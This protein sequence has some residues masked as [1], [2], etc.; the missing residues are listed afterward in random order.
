M[1]RVGMVYSRLRNDERM[2]LDA[3]RRKGIDLV[4][5]FDDEAVLDVH[6]RPWDADVVLERSISFY[7]GL[8]VLKF[9]KT[10][11]WTPPANGKQP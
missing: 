10:G 2:L 6:R 1:V 7:R 3:A 9:D 4:P 8:Y 11:T 5:L